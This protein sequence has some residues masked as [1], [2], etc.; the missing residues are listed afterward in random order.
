MSIRYLAEELYRL[1]RRVEDLEKALAALGIA[2][3]LQERTRLE[4]EL[5]RARKELAHVRAVLDS[6]KEPPKI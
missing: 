5:H 1:T 6:K 2:A 4:M 3:P